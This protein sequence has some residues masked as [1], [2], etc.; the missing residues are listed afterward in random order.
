M[1][2]ITHITSTY[3]KVN[4]LFWPNLIVG[5]DLGVMDFYFLNAGSVV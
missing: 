3:E 4:F 1:G 2:P 5:D